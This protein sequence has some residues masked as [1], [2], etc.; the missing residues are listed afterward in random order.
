MRA[1]RPLVWALSGWLAAGCAASSESLPAIRYGESTCAECHML[2]NEARYAAAAVTKADEP[3]VFDS[4]EC[5][6]RYLHRDETSLARVWVHD[7]EA[8]RWLVS[9]EAFYVASQEL[10]TPMGQGVVA[11]ASAS[12][13]DRL[14]GTVHGRVM[15]FA[16][17]AA[18]IDTTATINESRSP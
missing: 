4:I 16:Q 1:R 8:D 3:V 9:D 17:L 12:E 15:R 2:I 13:A 10:T 18:L 11:T 5:L 7:Y 14:A 6:V